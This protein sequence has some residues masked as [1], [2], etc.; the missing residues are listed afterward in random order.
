MWRLVEHE[1]VGDDAD[2]D[3]D[4]DATGVVRI[5]VR[6]V[7]SAKQERSSRNCGSRPKHAQ[8]GERYAVFE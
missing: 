3:T 7:G 5:W 8:S 4:T 2:T 1:V 6:V